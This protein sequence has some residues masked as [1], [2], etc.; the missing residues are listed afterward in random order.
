MHKGGLV[1]LF[2]LS[3]SLL[4][5]QNVAH[6]QMWN[7]VLKNASLDRHSGDELGFSTSV[8][9]LWAVVGA[10]SNDFDLNGTT[11]SS[12]S[13][14]GYSEDAG[15][16]YVVSRFGSYWRSP[17]KLVSPDRQEFDQFGY[18]VAIHGST[19]AVGAPGEDH[20]GTGTS[21]SSTSQANY[22]ANSGSVYLFTRV[23]GAWAFTAKLTAPVRA[24]G[25]LFG[26][27]LALNGTTLFVGAPQEDED[28]SNANPLTNAGAVYRFTL[29]N[30]TWTLNQKITA[31]DRAAGDEFG[32]AL[33]FDGTTAVV[34]ARFADVSSVQ[35]AGAPARG[36]SKES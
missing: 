31:S 36:P 14:A 27:S 26:S 24:S 22:V 29:L 3:T 21:S 32:G 33:D 5:A 16:V 20:D 7:E 12:S 34:G 19:L 1:I 13:S 25:D 18:S 35:N 15:A 8:H 23:N 28:A 11:S 6:I 17:E 2:A 10:P 9:D 4:S 30:G